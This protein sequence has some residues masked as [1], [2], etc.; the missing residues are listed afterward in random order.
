MRWSPPGMR[1]ARL[2]GG[3]PLAWLGLASI[4]SREQERSLARVA[5]E[6]G[7]SLEFR[8]RLCQPTGPEQEIASRRRKGRIMAQ[9]IGIG[10]FVEQ[11]EAGIGP[12][13]HTVGN[14]AIEIDDR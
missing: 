14:G 8:P 11:L 9:G 2:S 12:E 7:G 4:R 1:S 10:D 13:R 6:R 5:G 3:E